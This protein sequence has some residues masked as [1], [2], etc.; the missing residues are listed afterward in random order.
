V[1]LVWVPTLGAASY[2]IYLSEG[3]AAFFPAQTGVADTR[4]TVSGLAP[5]RSYRLYVRALDASG[6]EVAR[7][8]TVNVTTPSASSGTPLASPSPLRPTPTPGGS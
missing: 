6:Q 3:V 1:S 5:G 7:S 8:N 4:T 2:D